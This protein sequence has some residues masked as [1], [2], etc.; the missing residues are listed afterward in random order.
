MPT[1]LNVTMF[2][3]AEFCV[4]SSSERDKIINERESKR[5]NDRRKREETGDSGGG[6]YYAGFL[7]TLRVNHW[8]TNDIEKL[9]AAVIDL[10]LCKKGNKAKLEVYRQLKDLYVETWRAQD[11]ASYFEVPRAKV[12]FTGLKVTVDPEVGMRAGRTERALKLRF[13]KDK[14]LSTDLIEVC[15]YLL[16]EAARGGDWPRPWRPGIWD[17]Y[18][19]RLVDSQSPLDHMDEWVDQCAAE[20]VS[21]TGAAR[22]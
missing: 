6:G 4:G 15:D 11:G 3:F 2:K 9:E 10:D 5:E 19:S 20:F 22:P 12:P 7:K 1:D 18:R 8:E 13:S 16:F 21:L 17:V 14:E